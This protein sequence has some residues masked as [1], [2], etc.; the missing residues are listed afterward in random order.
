ML[1][2]ASIVQVPFL[3]LASTFRKVDLSSLDLESDEALCFFANLYHLLVRHMLLVL[4]APP[5]AKVN[6]CWGGGRA[7]CAGEQWLPALLSFVFFHPVTF[8]RS[9]CLFFAVEAF[10]F[11]HSGSFYLFSLSKLLSFLRCPT[12]YLFR[13]CRRCHCLGIFLLI[14]AEVVYR[15]CDRA[16]IRPVSPHFFLGISVSFVVKD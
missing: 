14:T 8:C 16:M 9:I 11:F 5:S 7:V 2:L 6:V 10:S 4:G 12:F 15:F 3:D 13:R 1:C